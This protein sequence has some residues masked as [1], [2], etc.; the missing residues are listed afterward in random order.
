MATSSTKH[1]WPISD[2]RKVNNEIRGERGVSKDYCTDRATMSP[3]RATS[4]PYIG[5]AEDRRRDCSQVSRRLLAQ[6][7]ITPISIN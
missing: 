7:P 2:I 1:K 3:F 4:L 5:A 6:R